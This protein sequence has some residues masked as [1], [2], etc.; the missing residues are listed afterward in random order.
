MPLATALREG[1]THYDLAK[2]R[3]DA[4]AGLIVSLV[5][6]PLSMALAIAVGLPPQHGLYT[7]IVAG[8]VTALCGGSRF[9]VS[10]PTAAFVVILAPIVAEHGLRG[11]IWCQIIAGIMLLALGVSRLGKA[12]N[13]VPHAVTTGFTTG[14]AVVI[15]TIALTDLF[16]LPSGFAAHWLDKMAHLISHAGAIDLATLALGAVSIAVMIAVPRFNKLIPGPLVAMLI[17]TGLAYALNRNG[18]DIATIG[19]KFTYIGKDGLDHAGVPPYPPQLNLP[20]GSNPLFALPSMAEL[21]AWFTPALVIAALAALE[22]LL[23][24]TIADKMSGTKHDPNAELNGIGLGNIAS[25]LVAGI[26]ATG[27]IARTAT[28]IAAGAVSPLSSIIH[29]V[30]L[31]IYMLALSPLIAYVPM[32]ALS[33]LLLMTA[34]RMSHVKDFMAVAKGNNKGDAAV[35]LVCFGLT[36]LID[37]VAGVVTG[38]ALATLLYLNSRDAVAVEPDSLWKRLGRKLRFWK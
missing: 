31:V 17:A 21:R 19:S 3:Q 13:Y 25:G 18:F 20:G 27:A 9:Q 7:A 10:G 34:W 15:A 38:M 14:I 16:G 26:P 37:M 24:A 29:A 22:S 23:S 28:N 33:A 11:I 4:T 1:L 32:T 12:I 30:L 2:F 36:V 35:L 5:A 8:I 6:L